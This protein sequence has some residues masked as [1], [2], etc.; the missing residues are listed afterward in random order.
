[1]KGHQ[2]LV[3]AVAGDSRTD[4]HLDTHIDVGVTSQPL[5]PGREAGADP[6]ASRAQETSRAESEDFGPLRTRKGE[7]EPKRSSKG[8][9]SAGPFSPSARAGFFFQMMMLEGPSWEA[10]LAFLKRARNLADARH[11]FGV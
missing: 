1:M 5:F 6:L 11:R 8:R 2:S 7:A 10:M 3:K 9:G 4:R